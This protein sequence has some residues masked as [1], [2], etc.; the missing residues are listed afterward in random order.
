MIDFEQQE[1]DSEYREF[2]D[3]AK[4]YFPLAGQY[5]SELCYRI[6]RA[7]EQRFKGSMLRLIDVCL[8]EE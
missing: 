3:F 7:V 6:A 4:R 8:K 2:A 1:P 5:N